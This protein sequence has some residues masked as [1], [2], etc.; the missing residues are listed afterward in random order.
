MLANR[1]ESMI[2]KTPSESVSNKDGQV[3][4][5][6]RK[7]RVT[8]YAIR[9]TNEDLVIPVTMEPNV[10]HTCKGVKRKKCTKENASTSSVGFAK[11]PNYAKRKMCSVVY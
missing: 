11:I 3:G 2:K 9:A 6:G 5:L 8:R 10:S 4:I 1:L 7:N